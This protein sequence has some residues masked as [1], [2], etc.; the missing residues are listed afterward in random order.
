MDKFPGHIACSSF[1]KSEIVVPLY[2]PANGTNLL[3]G[4]LDV[5]SEL[6]DNF[7][8]TDYKYL[9][10]ICKLISKGVEL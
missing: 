7:D 10:E 4:V 8:Q 3:L 9:N 2:D 6:L 1:S 5:D